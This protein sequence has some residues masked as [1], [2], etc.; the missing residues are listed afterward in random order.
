MPHQQSH[1]ARVPTTS[2]ME[3]NNMKLTNMISLGKNSF[4]K[5]R[6]RSSTSPNLIQASNVAFSCRK[7]RPAMQMHKGTSCSIC[8]FLGFIH[9]HMFRGKN[10]Q[11]NTSV[12]LWHFNLSGFV[13]PHQ[14]YLLKC[15]N[16]EKC[17]QKHDHLRV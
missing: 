5:C 15:K 17:H 3:N 13:F 14:K 1:V 16:S 12:G 11:K 7:T 6:V 10:Q 8:L 4:F 9:I 2:D